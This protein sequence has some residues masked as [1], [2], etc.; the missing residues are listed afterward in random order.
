[1]TLAQLILEIRRR[2]ATMPHDFPR[3]SALE[4]AARELL[5]DRNGP[6]ERVLSV[7]LGIGQAE[8]LDGWCLTLPIYNC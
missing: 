8:S 5:S 7:L 2:A 4:K 1:M 6:A 3:E